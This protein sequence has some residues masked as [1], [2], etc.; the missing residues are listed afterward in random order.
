MAAAR[1]V[2]AVDSLNGLFGRGLKTRILAN[3]VQGLMFSVLWRFFLD[4][5]NEKTK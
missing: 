2:I 3:G 1:E 5:W 4:L